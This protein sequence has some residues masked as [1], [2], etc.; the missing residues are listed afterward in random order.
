MR[1]ALI[2]PVVCASIIAGVIALSIWA[3]YMARLPR[4]AVVVSGGLATVDAGALDRAAIRRG[5]DIDDRRPIFTMT[6]A[7]EGGVVRIADGE[8]EDSYDAYMFVGAFD[9]DAVNNV[10]RRY[11]S[12]HVA[13][14][15]SNSDPSIGADGYA[16]AIS[17][18]AHEL[19]FLAG[20]FSALAAHAYTEDEEHDGL[21]RYS[22]AVVGMEDAPAAGYLGALRFGA[23][24]VNSAL[25]VRAVSTP[26]GASRDALETQMMQLY[27]RGARLL[28][29]CCEMNRDMIGAA[30]KMGLKIVTIGGGH[31]LPIGVLADFD[32]GWEEILA[33]ALEHAVRG[34]ANESARLGI[35]D[36]VY[37]ITMRRSAMRKIGYLYEQFVAINR[38][39]TAGEVTLPVPP[40]DGAEN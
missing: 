26:T 8:R 22:V 40:V 20:Y 6:R 34:G 27:A 3:V 32:I 9:G 39:L 13:L 12:R 30:R 38:R 15:S 11:P 28:V 7:G 5:L 17:V 1:G 24:A 35:V 18:D 19:F 10:A 2:A 33:H 14:L 25:P 23:H 31:R 16:H 29:V 37:V 36:N 4:V 21:T